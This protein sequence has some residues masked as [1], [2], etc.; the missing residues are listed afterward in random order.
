MTCLGLCNL[1]HPAPDVRRTA[2]NLLEEV[3]KQSDGQLSLAQFESALGSSSPIIYLHA[4]RRLSELLAAEH[5]SQSGAILAQVA[6]RLPQVYDNTANPMHD[7][8]L[9]FLESWISVIDLMP[10]GYSQLSPE[11]YRAL[12]N[13]YSLTYSYGD[14]YPDQIQALWIRLVE[15]QYPMNSSATVKFLIEQAARRGNLSFITYAGRIIAALS[16]TP[17][18]K[19]A[20]EDLCSVM[21][22]SGMS[23]VAEPEY[24]QPEDVG[25]EYKADLGLILPPDQ[26]RPSLGTGQLAMLFLSDV[27]LERSWD[28]RPQLP[29]LLH[30]LFTHFDHRLLYVEEQT[31]KMLFQLLRA[32]IPGYDELPERSKYPSYSALKATIDS[33]QAEGQKLFWSE[34]HAP[35]TVATK[36]SRLC[37]EVIRILEPLHPQLRRE[38]SDIALNWGTACA[39][40]S[41]AVR[42]L[43]LF[44][45]LMPMVSRGTLAGLLGRLSNTIADP[46]ESIQA[47][48]DELLLTLT[49]LA[50]L[51]KLDSTLLPQFFW[52]IYACLSTTVEQE[53]LRAVEAMNALLDKLDFHNRETIEELLGRKPETWAGPSQG[54]QRLLILGLRSSVTSAASFKL[55][56]RLAEYDDNELLA[57]GDG[58]L[59]DLFTVCLPWCLNAMDVDTLPPNAI[60][61]GEKLARLADNANLPN[62]S[63]IMISFSK[64]RF[65]TKDDFLRQ[66]VA[67][68]RE[69][70]APK[71]WTE[72]ATLL[73]GLVLNPQRWLRLKAMQVLKGLF[74]HR[75]SRNPLELMGS[76]LLM[77]LLRLLQ[78]DL[79][80]QALEV[81]DEPVA[82]GGNGPKATQVSPMMCHRTNTNISFIRCCG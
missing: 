69:Y 54:L 55:L 35:S 52:S 81:L 71:H 62:L 3:H 75:E 68:L 70:F 49:A 73:L 56:C 27:A 18:G 74:S 80:S 45:V 72:V 39:S 42:S 26:T 48:T 41:V 13:L 9:H 4:Q 51:D 20:V 50:K 65:R 37:T 53:Y 76:E 32:W 29:T 77:P 12:C 7:K 19:R 34:A 8:V 30:A 57:P 25:N 46:D 82:L 43:Q 61:L 78:T 2:Y 16:R 64:C 58:R 24:S 33:L 5:G 40:R 21:D 28:L 23:Q 59:R 47:F 22:P 14:R 67:C 66:S 36:M 15:A 31:Q 17:I 44:R 1:S 79:A 38:W 60:L 10:E 63:R 11:G 6:M